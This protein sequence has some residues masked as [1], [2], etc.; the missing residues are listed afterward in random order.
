MLRS[1]LIFWIIHP[2]SYITS[3]SKHQTGRRILFPSLHRVNEEQ[4]NAPGSARSAPVVI[5]ESPSVAK[6]KEL[7]GIL[8]DPQSPR[9]VARFPRAMRKVNLPQ[10]PPTVTKTENEV[11][12]N[13]ALS[14]RGNSRRS[15]FGNAWQ[16]KYSKEAR[17][18]LISLQS[19]EFST[20]DYASRVIRFDARITVR[21]FVRDREEYMTWYGKAE[22]E[23]FKRTAM[24]RICQYDIFNAKPLQSAE[25]QLVP[26]G[27]PFIVTTNR[28]R[29]KRSVFFTHPAIAMDSDEEMQLISLT[30]QEMQRI[31]VVDPHY[32]Y[33]KLYQRS[34]QGMLPYG[35]VLTCNSAEDA[36]ERLENCNFDMIVVDDS[37]AKNIVINQ[38]TKESSLLVSVSI[39]QDEPSDWADICWTKPPPIMNK[40]LRQNLVSRLLQKRNKDPSRF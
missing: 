5:P 18:S 28:I 11:S 9:S 25:T 22:M 32:V 27:T 24:E 39:A 6:L 21:E 33:L 35:T 37:L 34:L 26:T 4:T 23:R 7:R 8:H 2:A 10:P 38:S 16:E 29:K 14:E 36:S 17:L 31:L 3:G 13:A 20:N 1:Q 15:L 30:R 12:E 19:D 40:Q